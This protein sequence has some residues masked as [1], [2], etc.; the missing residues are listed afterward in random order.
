[1][2]EIDEPAIKTPLSANTFNTNGI[3]FVEQRFRQNDALH[4]A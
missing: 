4:A 1:M 3:N 2:T